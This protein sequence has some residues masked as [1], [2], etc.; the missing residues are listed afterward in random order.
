MLYSRSS[1]DGTTFESQR[2]LITAATNRDSGGS[3]TTDARGGVF[4]AWH[5]NAVGDEG[6]E[7]NRRVW[8]ARSLDDGGPFDRERPVWSQQRASV[9]AAVCA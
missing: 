4:V 2:N 6:T 5:G 1:R 8:I 9:A 7:A 3:L